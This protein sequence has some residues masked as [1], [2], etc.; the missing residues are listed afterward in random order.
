MSLSFEA[1]MLFSLRSFELHLFL[2]DTTEHHTP[3]STFGP[4]D[5]ILD[6]ALQPGGGK[7]FIAVI[8]VVIS[9]LALL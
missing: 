4:F 6:L 9:K 8:L 2:G 1:A 3:W 5:G 7:A